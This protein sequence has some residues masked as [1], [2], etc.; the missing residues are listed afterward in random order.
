M[1]YPLLGTFTLG[2]LLLGEDAEVFLSGLLGHE[3]PVVL[4]EHLGGVACL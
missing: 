4:E 2:A 3:L 1:P